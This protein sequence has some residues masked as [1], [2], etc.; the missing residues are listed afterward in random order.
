VDPTIA[1][2]TWR[3]LEPYHGMIYF[4]PEGPAA[5]SAIGLSDLRAGYF[6]SRSAPMGAVGASV[7][8]ATFFNFHPALVERAVPAC[9]EQCTP[10]QLVSARFGAADAALERVLGGDIVSSPAMEEAATLAHTAATAPSLSAAGRP[11]Y[12]GHASLVWP[13]QPHLVLWHA[14]S[15]LREYRGD[16]HI[17]ALVG[18][19]MDGCEALVCHAATGDVPKAALRATRQWPQSSWEAAVARLQDRGW[20]LPDG[21][22]TPDGRASRQRVEDLTDQLAVA[23]WAHLGEEKCARLR[24]LVRPWSRAIVEGGGLATMTAS[25]A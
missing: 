10:A 5:Y 21:S 6:A 9:W 2:K 14:I 24:E 20:L 25:P 7:V 15:I 16:G 19:G 18:E 3:T 4:V 12:A 17:A 1:R 22:F 23:P 8:V 11:L 13:T